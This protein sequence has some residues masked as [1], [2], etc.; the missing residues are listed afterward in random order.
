MTNIV[1]IE[2]LL[3]NSVGVASSLEPSST[4]TSIKSTKL[5]RGRR[6][7]PANKVVPKSS[8][9][10]DCSDPSILLDKIAAEEAVTTSLCVDFTSSYAAHTKNLSYTQ[11]TGLQQWIDNFAAASW[12]VLDLKMACTAY[13]HQQSA[14]TSQAPSP[15]ISTLAYGDGVSAIQIGCGT[16]MVTFDPPDCSGYG[17][18]SISNFQLQSSVLPVC[19]A[20]EANELLITTPDVVTQSA[21]WESELLVSATT[22]MAGAP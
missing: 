13:A 3:R 12:S 14:G 10:V 16:S 7:D 4:P 22:A 11:Q 9:D 18:L 15:T 19:A 21:I 17:T 8:P 5:L 6:Q 1:L 2:L 20:V